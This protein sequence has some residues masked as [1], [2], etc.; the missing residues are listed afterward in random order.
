MDMRDSSWYRGCTKARRGFGARRLELIEKLWEEQ[1]LLTHL[2]IQGQASGRTPEELEQVK[3]GIDALRVELDEITLPKDVRSKREIWIEETQL[4]RNVANLPKI[5][6]AA[7]GAEYDRD[8]EERVWAKK[9]RKERKTDHP[10]GELGL[11]ADGILGDRKVREVLLG[12]IPFG[13]H[14]DKT[15]QTKR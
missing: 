8:L 10:G 12:D 1:N 14:R 2:I 4:Q 7:L 3:K 6:D 5:S 13:V 9:I 11:I 15:V